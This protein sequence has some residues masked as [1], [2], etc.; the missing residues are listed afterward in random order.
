MGIWI[1]Q[2]DRRGLEQ[3]TIGVKPGIV[4]RVVQDGDR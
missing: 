4:R 1:A 2:C 3:L